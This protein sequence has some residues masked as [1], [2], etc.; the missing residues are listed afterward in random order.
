MISVADA[1][2]IVQAHLRPLGTELVPLRQAAGRVL[3][4]TLITDRPLPP[5]HRVAMDGI[6][7]RYTDFAAGQRIFPIAGTSPAGSPVLTMTE[8]GHC[9][10][11][12]TGSVLPIGTD[13]VIRYEDILLDDGKALVQLDRINE[14]Q[15][16]HPLGKDQPQ[17]KPIAPIG[18]LVDAAIS[19]VAAAVGKTHLLV[20]RRPRVA[21]ISTGD[22]LVGIDVQP[23]P[24]QIRRS[25]TYSISVL[26][27]ERVD[28][29]HDFHLPDDYDTI[30]QQ[31]QQLLNN[32]DVLILSG[33]V[34]MG[35]FDYLPQ[36]LNSLGVTQHFHK[37][38]QRPGKPFWFGASKKQNTIVFAL[39]GNPVSSLACT[40]VYVLPWLRASQQQLESP[41]TYA[42]LADDV[43]FKPD[44][45]YFLQ[46]RLSS[47]P[48]GVLLAHPE[49]GNGSGDFSNLVRA[50]ALL[51][52]PRGKDHFSA[53]EA[54]PVF[55]LSSPS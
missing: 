14:G 46:V 48:T 27:A 54:F 22:E 26:L 2:A 40:L 53:G 39:P 18:S 6:A 38:R 29:L 51:H 30:R 31:L 35:K 28:C 17:G 32:Y 44:L 9:I 50:D 7:L 52:L 33:G 3:R 13:S 16:V 43:S 10:E 8:S 42:Q 24:H 49:A 19:G 37:V 5:Y 4:E 11:V 45:D 20:S 21:V 15:N 23:A 25:N 41:T 36:A 34:S 1:Q 12:M 47:S 55:L